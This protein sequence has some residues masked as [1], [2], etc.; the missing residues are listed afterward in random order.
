MAYKNYIGGAWVGSHSGHVFTSINPANGEVLGEITRSDAQDVDRA[1]Q[2]AS[3]AFDSWRK[4]PA[5]RRAEMLYRA[6]DILARR[7]EDLARFLTREMGKVLPEA[8]GD[9]QEAID[10]AYY[11]A[12]EGRRLFGYTVPVELPDKFGMCVREPVGV[13]A[14]ITPWNFPIAIPA[15]K[16]FP[17]LVAGNTAS[18]S[19]PATPLSWA[20]SS[21]RL[22]RRQVSRPA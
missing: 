3:V 14:A 21:S 8:R 16:T 9:V 19:P 7:K 18:S 5:P 10:M 20:S 6:G 4:T 15:W 13:V 1:V 12:G 17:A 11:M 22:L 2:A